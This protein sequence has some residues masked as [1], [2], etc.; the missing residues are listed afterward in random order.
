MPFSPHERKIV[1]SAY[2]MGPKMVGYLEA[3][4]ID[5]LEALAASDAGTLAANINHH[6]GRPLMNSMGVAAL[7]N[8]ILAAQQALSHDGSA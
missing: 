1:L 7:E 3:I 6:I 5:R 8:A 4:G 2:S